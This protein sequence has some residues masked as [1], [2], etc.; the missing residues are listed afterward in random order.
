MSIELKL[1]VQPKSGWIFRWKSFWIGLHYS[2][3]NNRY[4]LNPIPCVTYWWIGEG[5][6]VPAKSL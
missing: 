2:D 1:S 3:F 4:C 5:G 6:K